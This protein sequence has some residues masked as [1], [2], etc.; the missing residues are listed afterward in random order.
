M[1]RF[2]SALDPFSE[3]RLIGK[4]LVLAAVILAM[5]R[6]ERSA[7]LPQLLGGGIGRSGGVSTS[8]STRPS[9]TPESRAAKRP[10]SAYLTA[11][12]YIAMICMTAAT[13]SFNLPLEQR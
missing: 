4:S 8:S 13:L 7:S 12:H 10:A 1:P 3:M 11:R 5:A 2:G 9:C 6:D